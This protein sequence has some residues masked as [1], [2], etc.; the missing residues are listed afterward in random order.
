[1]LGL[2]TNMDNSRLLMIQSRVLHFTFFIG[3]K[4]NS[5]KNCEQIQF[6]YQH[7]MFAF[8]GFILS[9][10]KYSQAVLS[11]VDRH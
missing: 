5:R 2:E 3:L 6:F 11:K 10:G 8:Y 1:M 9:R 4:Y 7:C